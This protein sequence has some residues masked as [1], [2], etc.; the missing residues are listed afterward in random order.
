[1]KMDLAYIQRLRAVLEVISRSH[2]FRPGNERHLR[3]LVADATRE[4]WSVIDAYF[5]RRLD[6]VRSSSPPDRL[7][8]SFRMAM[9]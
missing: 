7:A 1:M 9:R 2:A 4:N 3:V 6:I 8:A 5:N